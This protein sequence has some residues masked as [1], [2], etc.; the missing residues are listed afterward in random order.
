[1]NKKISMFIAISLII[2][3]LVGCA[4]APAVT[5]APAA[6]ATEAPA[7]AAEAPAVDVSTLP[8][9][10]KNWPPSRCLSIHPKRSPHTVRMEMSL[11]GTQNSN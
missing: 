6:A 5:E 8:E 9:E 11:P 7:A 4:P 1:M 10:L 3:M 2:A